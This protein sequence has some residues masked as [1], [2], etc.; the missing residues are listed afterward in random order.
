[1]V[2]ASF[3]A[4]RVAGDFIFFD[5]AAGAQIPQ[6][7]LDAVNRHLIEHNVQRGGRYRHS[8]AVD[9]AISGAR[10][11]VAAV[12]NAYDPHENSFGMNATSFMRLVSWGI[13]RSL[14]ERR[15]I[16][17]TDMDHESNVATWLDL[18]RDGAKF[19]WWRMRE[20]GNL[21]LADLEPL[22]SPRTRLVACTV[23]S[24]AIGSIVDVAGGA[25]RS[26]ARGPGGFFHLSRHAPHRPLSLC[27]ICGVDR[28]W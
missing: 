15:E 6:I 8:R 20:D 25:K 23:T 10:E 13:G 21:H 4:L 1:E 19:R 12:L 5:N 27:G 2:R 26:R 3:P 28:W 14:G 7:V 11:S 9:A 18:A 16:I 22:L 17:V 24:N